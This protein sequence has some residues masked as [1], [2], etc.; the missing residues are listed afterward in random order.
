MGTVHVQ[1]G[2]VALEEVEEYKYLGL[3]LEKSGRWKK[4]KEKMLC[5]ARMAGC[6]AWAMVVRVG[7]MTVKGMDGMWKALIRPHLE[8]GAEVMNS[9]QDYLWEDAE[10]LMRANGRRVLLCGSR[11]PNE[12]VMGELG[13]ISMRGDGGLT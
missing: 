11:V 13:W 10:K 9:H 2:G 1:W 3:L 7:N 12:A 8:Y 4:E 6:M 5:K